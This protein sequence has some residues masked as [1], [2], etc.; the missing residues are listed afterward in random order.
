MCNRALP[1]E[2]SHILLCRSACLRNPVKIEAASKFSTV[3]TLKEQYLFVPA[4]YKACYLIYGLTEISGSSS[5]LFTGM[6][7]V[8]FCAFLWNKGQQIVKS[9]RGFLESSNHGKEKN[10]CALHG[11]LPKYFSSEWLVAQF[12]LQE[13]RP[14]LTNLLS[15]FEDLFSIEGDIA[16]EQ[17]A[18]LFRKDGMEVD[19]GN[20]VSFVTDGAWIAGS[21]SGAAAC[22]LESSG[23]PAVHQSIT[24]LASSASAMEVQGKGGLTVIVYIHL[25]GRT[26]RPG[27]TGCAISLISPTEVLWFLQIEKH[28]EEQNTF[29]SNSRR[30]SSA[31]VGARLRG[32]K[33]I[34][35]GMKFFAVFVCS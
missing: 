35:N 18:S 25:V 5:M 10:N 16:G 32:Q 6:F 19:H 17:F 30:R 20:L 28:M 34:R 27:R 7:S 4:K 21:N 33:N 15:K 8:W 23:G 22:V 26:A 29:V 24:C 2:S 13:V 31:A 1:L 11:V 12:R 9:W 3:D 14:S